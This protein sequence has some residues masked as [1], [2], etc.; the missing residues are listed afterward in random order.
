MNNVTTAIITIASVI[1]ALT[2][3]ISSVRIVSKKYREN[4]NKYVSEQ[5]APSFKSI[6]DNLNTIQEDLKNVSIDNDKREMQRLRYECLRFASEVRK[7]EAKTRQE[8]EEIFRM[9]ENYDYMIDKYEIKNGFM[10]EEMR[11]VHE[12]YRKLNN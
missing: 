7:G 11:Y 1:T 12:Q 6:N 3:I 4:M 10:E 2:T 5:L 9:E 8:Y